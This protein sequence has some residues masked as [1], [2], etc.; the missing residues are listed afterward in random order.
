MPNHC[1]NDLTVF[2][3]GAQ[4]NEFLNMF[5]T[6]E[7]ATMNKIVPMPQDLDSSISPLPKREGETDKQYTARMRNYKKLYG[8]DNWYDWRINN[9]G[10]KWDLYEF[11]EIERNNIN[12]EFAFSCSFW[13]AWG[14]PIL[15]L[16]KASNK[17]PSINFHFSYMEPGGGF[18]GLVSGSGHEGLD[19]QEGDIVQKDYDGNIV[20]WDSKIMLYRNHKDE[21]INDEDFIAIDSNP[22]I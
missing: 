3:E 14:P 5:L 17:F 6:N 16:Y 7:G 15:W 19:S 18:C 4:V 8:A 2:G 20:T 21:I 22:F 1:E 13:T 11:Y 9:W 12:G 10:T